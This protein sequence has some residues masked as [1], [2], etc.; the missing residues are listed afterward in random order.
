MVKCLV[1][2]VGRVFERVAWHC[3]YGVKETRFTV[4][5][6]YGPN[7]DE[8][9]ANKDFFYENVQRAITDF[10]NIRELVVLIGD[11]YCPQWTQQQ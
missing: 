9:I 4:T 8:S 3:V 2:V 11:F 7:E 6:D 5:G 1:D 10:G